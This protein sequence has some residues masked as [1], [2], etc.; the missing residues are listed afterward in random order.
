LENQMVDA[1]N[2]LFQMA[3]YP[4]FERPFPTLLP[5]STPDDIVFTEQKITLNQGFQKDAAVAMKKLAAGEDMDEYRPPKERKATYGDGLRIFYVSVRRIQMELLSKLVT[6]EMTNNL[7]GATNRIE[8]YLKLP[9]WRFKKYAEQ[10]SFPE[11]IEEGVEVF[12]DKTKAIEYAEAKAGE[13][14]F[15]FEKEPKNLGADEVLYEVPS[16]EEVE[17]GELGNRGLP[18]Y[19]KLYAVKTARITQTGRVPEWCALF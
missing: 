7:T 13:A 14:R 19:Y 17:T 15:T 9:V 18:V 16:K 2:D 10:S 5:D 8:D 3:G 12:T 1:V 6:I 11:P 4:D